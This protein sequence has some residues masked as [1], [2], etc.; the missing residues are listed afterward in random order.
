[1]ERQEMAVPGSWANARFI[2][3]MRDYYKFYEICGIIG[4]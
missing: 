4:A 1:M 3:K 2:A